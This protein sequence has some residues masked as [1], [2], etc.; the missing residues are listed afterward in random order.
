[1]NPHNPSAAQMGSELL[2]LGDYRSTVDAFAKP[3]SYRKM[4][5]WTFAEI[6]SMP[7]NKQHKV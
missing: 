2:L 4:N 5:N 1:M 7:D 3:P 6:D